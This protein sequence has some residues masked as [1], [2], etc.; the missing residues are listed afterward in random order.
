MQG[1]VH[2]ELVEG[3]VEEGGVNGDDRVQSAGG[4]TGRGDGGV[5]LGDADVPHPVREA[6]GERA[7]A[8][9]V[10]HGGGDGHHVL[11]FLADPDDLLP[12]DRGPGRPAGGGEG[13]AGERVHHADGV[14]VVLL[15]GEGGFV[16]AA[17][18]GDAVDEDGAVE[19]F[20]AA[21][22]G[23]HGPD[24]VAVDRAD[25]LQAQVLEE[26]LGGE[27][28]L[29]ALLRAV[30][31]LVD[32]RADHGGALEDVLAPGQ[33]AFVAVGGAQGGEVVGEA[34]DGG[35]VGAFVVVDD[36]DERTVLGGGD[37]VQ[38][39]P[40]HAAGERAVTDHRDDVSLLP[41]HPAGLGEPVG[42][43]ECGGGVAVLD[44]VVLG[45]L[46][47]GVAG[48]AALAAQLGEVLTAG[49]QLVHIALVAGV[50]QDAVHRRLEDP[51]QGDGQLHHPEVG[52]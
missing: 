51:V 41:A 15:V 20:G 26:A 44:D 22:R 5:L 21:Q 1:H 13:R 46:A 7:E 40:G 33:D 2:Q 25:V 3:A 50:P 19:A 4:E 32:G 9:R 35:G 11:A 31:R 37:V 34:A 39:L 49:Q 10:E 23:L 28:V 8:H 52:S 18:L 38:R 16:A 29:E 45:L 48:E 43:A 6:L 12:E 36:D 14:E 27:G 42:P 24:V 47:G 17:L 30:Q